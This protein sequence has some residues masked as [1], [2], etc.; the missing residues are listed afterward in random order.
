MTPAEKAQALNDAGMCIICGA[1]AK[2]RT[3]GLCRMHHGRFRRK[4]DSLPAE[5]REQFE[6]HLIEQGLVLPNRRVSASDRQ[7]LAFEQAFAHFQQRRGDAKEDGD[8]TASTS[9]SSQ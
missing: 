2:T 7:P 6:A 1:P 5:D 4:L 3:R 8:R 9:P